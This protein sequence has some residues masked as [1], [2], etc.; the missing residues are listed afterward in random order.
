METVADIREKYTALDVNFSLKKLKKRFTELMA[1]PDKAIITSTFFVFLDKNRLIYTKETC[2]PASMKARFF[3]HVIPVDDRHFLGHH[4]KRGFQSMSDRFSKQF[5]KI[6][7]Y[8][9][10]TRMALPFYPIRYIRTGQY[11]PDEGILWEGGAWIEPNGGGDDGLEFPVAAGK[12]IIYSD[13]DL[14]LDGLHLVYHKAECGPADREP[15]FFLHVT[16]TDG[17]LLPSDRVQYGFDKLDFNNCT[18]EHRLPAY[19]IRHIRTGQYTGD[20]RLWEV[21]FPLDQASGRRGDERA[22][23]SLRPV[24]SVF[25]VTLDGR[26]LIYRKAACRRADLEARFFVHL[27]PVDAIDLSPERTSYGFENLDFQHY[28]EFRVNEF[29]C[30]I[31][32]R[33]PAYAIRRIRTG[34]YMPGEGRLWEGAFAMTQEVQEQD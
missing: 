24:R 4:S 17:T 18:I 25:D 1:Q 31:A 16:P 8:G 5:L 23:G 15:P 33:L 28:S 19:A 9:C 2:S 34:Q 21:E 14:Y 29:G 32:R 11:V 13:F 22:G 26:R 12:R 7:R 27:T 6:G 10:A 30:T 20:G 3:L